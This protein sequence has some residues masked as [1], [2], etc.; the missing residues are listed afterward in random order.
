MFVVCTDRLGGLLIL[1]ETSIKYVDVDNNDFI[2]HPLEEA[3]IFVAWEQV[4]SQ[5][6]LLADDYGRL[7]LL[8]LILDDSTGEVS[9]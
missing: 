9:R 2:S 8:M 7:F 3:T 6:W 5:R 1:G 4:D